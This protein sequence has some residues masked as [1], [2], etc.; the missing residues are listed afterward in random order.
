MTI[1]G[2]DAVQYSLIMDSPISLYITKLEWWVKSNK[3]PEGTTPP[4]QPIQSNK[5]MKR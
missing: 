1:C 2:G 4:A 5:T 3:K